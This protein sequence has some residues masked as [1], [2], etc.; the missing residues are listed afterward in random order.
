MALAGRLVKRRPFFGWYIVAV[1][2]LGQIMSL[3]FQSYVFT[4]FLKPMT[5]ELHWSRAAFSSAASL[6]TLLTGVLALFIGGQLDRHGARGMMIV[7]GVLAGVAVAALGTVHTL[8]QFF[9]LRGVLIVPGQLLISNLV[10]NVVLAKWFVVHR[11]RAIAWAS[12]G[13]S[14]AGATLTP[15]TAWLIGQIG[16]RTTWLVL[17]L[18]TV[19][20]VAL[21]AALL[22]ARCPED[23]N[24][25]PDGLPE[26]AV[27]KFGQAARESARWTRRQVM[28]TPAMWL[29]A[30]AFGL[31][32]LGI[33][34]ILLHLVP[35]L[36]DA[37]YTLRE[38]TLI[39]ALLAFLAMGI[40]IPVGYLIEHLAARWSASICFVCTGGGLL[41]LLLTSDRSAVYAGT[42]LA[43]LGLGASFP[44]QETVW[45]DFYGRLTLGVV[46]SV[47]MPISVIFSAAGPFLA[48]YVY[49]R[50]GSYAVALIL[51]AVLYGLA[52]ILMLLARQP[53]PPL[54]ARGELLA[55]QAGISEPIQG[56]GLPS[57]DSRTNVL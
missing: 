55:Q 30:F 48:G 18:I 2:F 24:L 23:F 11:G 4:V 1:A 28:A 40:K 32:S 27:S 19:V 14:L 37:G 6:G 56:V 45:A 31:N 22:V 54:A 26:V 21:P 36:T 13:V 5:E 16:W 33:W 43:G 9:L 52:A 49:D 17:G 50:T 12:T 41:L 51:F 42:C 3:G 34:A 44:I 15:L 25:S 53:R 57:V 46:R 8:W 29:L 7:G 39:Y 20:A 35:L 47:G 38:A 10:V